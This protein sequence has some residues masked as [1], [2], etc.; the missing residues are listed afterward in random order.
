MRVFT[1]MQIA[2]KH[3]PS[4]GQFFEVIRML[5]DGF[6]KAYNNQRRTDNISML[7]VVL[8]G[9]MVH[10]LDAMCTSDIN[11]VVFYDDRHADEIAITEFARLHRD[12]YITSLVEAAKRNIPVKIHT[13]FWS[14]VAHRDSFYTKGFLERVLLLAKGSGSK[15]PASLIVGDL[16]A[17]EKL[18]IVAPAFTRE[19]KAAYI[20]SVQEKIRN[21]YLF[22][23]G[24][25]EN[26]QAEMYK[27]LFD[28]PFY[29]AGQVLDIIGIPHNGT[30]REVV[31]EIKKIIPGTAKKMVDIAQIAYLYG[32]DCD[33]YLHD[34]EQKVKRPFLDIEKIYRDSLMILEDLLKVV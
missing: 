10:Q 12:S 5:K 6:T 33:N 22:L 16:N 1:A 15:V 27:N 29:A 23:G 18:C 34:K 9:S 4:S 2:N 28:A 3:I 19:K 25:S 24:L 7:G 30:K 20:S 32:K 21:G 17:M 14:K 31:N 26:D 8:I 13:V 11:I